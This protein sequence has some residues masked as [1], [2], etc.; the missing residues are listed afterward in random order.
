MTTLL[1]LLLLTLAVACATEARA[2]AVEYD[3]HAGSAVVVTLRYAD[4]TPFAFEEAE[5]RDEASHRV[6]LVTRSDAQGRVVFLPPSEG[7]WIVRATSADGHGAEVRVEAS[8]LGDAV[9]VDSRRTPA[10]HAL[11]RI[12]VGVLLILALFALLARSPFM[13]GGRRRA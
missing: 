2:H 9:T 10:T 5:I 6:R 3:V 4:G 7:P 12:V 13:T 8:V 11:A 1:R